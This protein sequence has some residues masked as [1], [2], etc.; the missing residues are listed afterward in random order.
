MAAISLRNSRCDERNAHCSDS[1]SFKS[2]KSSFNLLPHSSI[3]LFNGDAGSSTLL[4]PSNL[5]GSDSTIPTA[6]PGSNGHPNPYTPLLPQISDVHKIPPTFSEVSFHAFDSSPP[7]SKDTVHFV[8]ND[9]KLLDR[10]PTAI[11]PFVSIFQPTID[12]SLLKP[13]QPPTLDGYVQAHSLPNLA[14]S[15]DPSPPPNSHVPIPSDYIPPYSPSA[16]RPPSPT[17]CNLPDMPGP[18]PGSGSSDSSSD[19]CFTAPEYKSET[20]ATSPQSG[21]GRLQATNESSN[22]MLGSHRPPSNGRIDQSPGAL[23]HQPIFADGKANS[24]TSDTQLPHSASFFL[25]HPRVR[26]PPSPKGPVHDGS[27]L[28]SA[29]HAAVNEAVTLWEATQWNRA[30]TLPSSSNPF[31][32]SSPEDLECQYAIAIDAK[33]ALTLRQLAIVADIVFMQQTKPG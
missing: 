26:N 11:P 22:H 18:P 33:N 7:E 4:K 32:C 28:T 29:I 30:S 21:L 12:K 13:Q 2:I 10:P 1:D 27:L 6:T 16:T 19:L 14:T 24:N 5:Y 8:A 17:H 15:V 23:Q 31:S 25:F 20:C 9:T 3:L